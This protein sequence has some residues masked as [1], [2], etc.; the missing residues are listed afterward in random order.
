MTIK[1]RRTSREKA[2]DAALTAGSVI[3]LF[4]IAGTA[5]LTLGGKNAQWGYTLFILLP[6]EAGLAAGMATWPKTTT[7][8]ALAWFLVFG[9]IGLQGL[10]L[11]GLVCCLMALP[12][13]LPGL[14]LGA[15]IG[16]LLVR[17]RRRP[18]VWALVLI[19]PT[20]VGLGGLLERHL[21]PSRPRLEATTT[22]AQVRAPVEVVWPYVL[23][24]EKME[25]PRPLLLRLGL[26]VPVRCTIEG[27]GLGAARTCY[28]ES[29]WI[30]ERV[31]VWDPPRRIEVEVTE[32]RIPGRHWLRFVS[33]AYELSADKDTTLVKRTTT[34]SSLL[35][36]SLYWGPLERVAIGA[37]HRYILGSLR[38]AAEAGSRDAVAAA[39]QRLA[40]AELPG[41]AGP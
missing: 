15:V 13:V 10:G 41:G 31:T 18:H 27:S 12:I 26:P 2:A 29:G 32:A 7:T 5:F 21:F 37:E 35:R 9:M 30:S 19:L 14:L 16:F 40:R 28:F 24:Q 17:R 20:A 11:E 8:L 33:A 39:P 25:G 23:A 1:A 34:I 36:P 6:V 38:H 22:T 4:G 3:A